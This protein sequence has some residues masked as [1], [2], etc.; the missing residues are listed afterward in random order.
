MSPYLAGGLATSADAAGVGAAAGAGAGAGCL[1]GCCA[2]AASA[3]AQ[4]AMVA[5][6]RIFPYG[7]M[8]VLPGANDFRKPN[9]GKRGNGA[10]GSDACQGAAVRASRVR[11]TDAE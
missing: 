4:A 5:S 3:S 9:C 8:I 6:V 7:I 11:I 10:P 1:A 2:D